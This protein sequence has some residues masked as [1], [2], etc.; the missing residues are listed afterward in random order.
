M[1]NWWFMCSLHNFC[2]PWRKFLRS[3]QTICELSSLLQ[4]EIV[5]GEHSPMESVFNN[6][7]VNGGTLSPQLLAVLAD[8]DMLLL[9]HTLIQEGILTLEQFQSVNPWVFMNRHAL[10]TIGQRQNICTRITNRLKD[11]ESKKDDQSGKYQLVIDSDSYS[12]ETPADVFVS[13]CERMEQKYPLKFKTVRN[14]PSRRRARKK[15]YR[16]PKGKFPPTVIWEKFSGIT[17]CP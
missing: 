6:Q 7:T 5:S 11:A 17:K 16:K 14:I 2:R 10:Y 3:S 8:E 12:G 1:Q 9:R 4:N 13:F 15:L